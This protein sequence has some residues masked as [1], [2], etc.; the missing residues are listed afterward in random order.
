LCVLRDAVL[1]IGVG[2][3]AIDHTD[4]TALASVDDSPVAIN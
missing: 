4:A 3:H 1:E 2:I